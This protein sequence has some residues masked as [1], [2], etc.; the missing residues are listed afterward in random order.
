MFGVTASKTGENTC[1]DIMKRNHCK[2][3]WLG[4]MTL[5]NGTAVVT[6]TVSI[7]EVEDV[8]YCAEPRADR[9]PAR[10]LFTKT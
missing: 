8:L 2:S 7:C 1:R 4:G 5:K 6:L 9:D 3:T 10:V